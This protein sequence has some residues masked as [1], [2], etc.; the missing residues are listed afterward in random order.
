MFNQAKIFIMKFW[1]FILKKIPEPVKKILATI[2]PVK[3][4]FN[5]G[6]IVSINFLGLIGIL[7]IAYGI[8]VAGD[9]QTQW[10]FLEETANTCS[11]Y[12]TLIGTAV[13]AASIYLKPN[14]IRPPETLSLWITAPV[15]IASI[16][17]TFC[18]QW[19]GNHIPSH[20]INGFSILAIAGALNRL[21]PEKL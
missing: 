4:L 1:G 17:F 19:N 6:A 13:T 2:V 12:A 21:V 16:L 11:N 5:Q 10:K 7:L 18:Y 15:V 9:P 8:I 14:T 3:K 20:V